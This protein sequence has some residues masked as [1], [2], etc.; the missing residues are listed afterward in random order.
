MKVL[1]VNYNVEN[2]KME[3]VKFQLGGTF[4]KLRARGLASMPQPAA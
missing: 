1:T 4:G 2:D 3:M